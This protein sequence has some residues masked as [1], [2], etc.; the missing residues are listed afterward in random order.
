V[1]APSCNFPTVS[2]AIYEY[3]LSHRQIKKNVAQETV[4]TKR[5]N[6]GCLSE[7]VQEQGGSATQESQQNGLAVWSHILR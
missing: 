1:S 7:N 5:K 3:W 6:G 2:R 4:K